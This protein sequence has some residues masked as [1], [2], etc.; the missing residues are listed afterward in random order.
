MHVLPALALASCLGGALYQVPP[1]A[2]IANP[3]PHLITCH[4][5]WPWRASVYDRVSG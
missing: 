5:S 4:L 3:H 2:A 1:V